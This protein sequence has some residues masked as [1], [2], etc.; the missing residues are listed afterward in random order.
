MTVKRSYQRSTDG[1]PAAGKRALGGRLEDVRNTEGGGIDLKGFLGRV[2]ERAKGAGALK[3]FPSY[4]AARYYHRGDRE[5]PVHYL[6]L[7]G[8]T[9]GVSLRWLATGRGPRREHVQ[10]EDAAPVELS[11]ADLKRFEIRHAIES[12]MP[13]SDDAEESQ[14]LLGEVGTDLWFAAANHLLFSHGR[15][16]EDWNEGDVW[17]A[18]RGLG[19]I[20]GVLLKALGREPERMPFEQLHAYVLA[21]YQATMLAIPATTSTRLARPSSSLVPPRRCTTPST[22]R[23]GRSCTPKT[24]SDHAEGEL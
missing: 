2:E 22:I 15:A 18:L 17:R 7:V 8:E 24:R 11:D 12:T 10:R 3:G 14:E 4:A 21:M 23:R 6:V 19:E 20:W 9:F 13:F 5:A 1:Q 16:P